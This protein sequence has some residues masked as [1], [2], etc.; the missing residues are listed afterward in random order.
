MESGFPAA[1]EVPWG[2]QHFSPGRTGRSTTP[3]PPEQNR[4]VPGPLD[5]GEAG[6]GETSRSKVGRSEPRWGPLSHAS[7]ILSSHLL[8]IQATL[9]PKLPSCWLSVRLLR[10]SW[11]H[12]QHSR[13]AH[14]VIP[15]H[16]CILP[17]LSR[18]PPP[19]PRPSPLA[20]PP[21]PPTPSPA[22]PLQP[23]LRTVPREAPD[24]SSQGCPHR[25]V[26]P[27]DASPGGSPVSPRPPGT[28]PRPRPPLRP[29]SS[30]LPCGC[31]GG[32][33]ASQGWWPPSAQTLKIGDRGRRS[34]AGRKTA[35]VTSAHGG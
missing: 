19:A 14:R 22:C 11:K 15:E 1:R 4:E 10:T 29:A 23:G 27:P 13:S 7:C 34:P 16:N 6:G 30:A 33:P 35:L 2:H 17:S 5:F 18:E 20:C 32:S 12:L 21:P 9:T 26:A 28:H 25:A 3:R 8:N 31:L 24:A